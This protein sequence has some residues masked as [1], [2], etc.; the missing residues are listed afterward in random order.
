M[1]TGTFTRSVGIR[2]TVVGTAHLQARDLDHG[3]ALGHQA[4]DVL[5]RVRSSRSA[6]YVRDFAAALGPWRREPAVGRF[7]ERTRS[8]FGGAVA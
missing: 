6:D 8:S 7:L 3:L 5:A 2:L 4:L 1:P